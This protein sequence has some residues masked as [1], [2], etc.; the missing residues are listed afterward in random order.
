MSGLWAFFEWAFAVGVL[1]HWRAALVAAG[2]LIKPIGCHTL[3]WQAHVTLGGGMC[4][5]CGGRLRCSACGQF[6]RE[7]FRSMHLMSIGCPRGDAWEN[8]TL[9]SV[10]RWKVF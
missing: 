4:V 5:L 9:Y 3:R 7:D 2:K 1:L 8:R 10:P 6:V